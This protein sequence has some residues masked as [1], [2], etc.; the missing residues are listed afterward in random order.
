MKHESTFH[1]E[2]PLGALELVNGSKLILASATH[3]ITHNPHTT[4]HTAIA[5]G[6]PSTKLHRS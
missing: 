3:M 5:T 4:C 2:S 1:F 6:L